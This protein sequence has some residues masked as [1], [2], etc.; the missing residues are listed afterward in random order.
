MAK[1]S[2]NILDEARSQIKQVD[3]DEARRMMEKPGTVLVDV[4][5][6]DALGGGHGLTAAADASALV[7]HCRLENTPPPP[8]PPPPGGAGGAPHPSP[9]PPPARGRG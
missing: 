6:P 8:P 4:R 3:I 2:K 9:P 7:P 1:T 5:E